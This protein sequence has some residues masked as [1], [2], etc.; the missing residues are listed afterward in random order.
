VR[1]LYGV[2][3]GP[4]DVTKAS[5]PFHLAVNGS[6]ENGDE[7]AVFLAGD[8]TAWVN[9]DAINAAEGLGVPPMRDLIDKVRKHRIPVYV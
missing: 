3:T 8:G 2:S 1:I 4:D 7:V 6:A 5:V 9:A